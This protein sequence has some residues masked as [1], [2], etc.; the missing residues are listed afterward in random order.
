MGGERTRPGSTRCGRRVREPVVAANRRQTPVDRRRRQSA[1]LHRRAVDLDVRSRRG[2]HLEARVGGPLE[3]VAQILAVRLERSAAVAGQERCSRQLRLVRRRHRLVGERECRGRHDQ[4][5][6]HREPPRFERIH[7]TRLDASGTDGP[8][9]QQPAFGG[10]IRYHG[11]LM[12]HRR[13]MNRTFCASRAAPRRD[14]CALNEAADVID[15]GHDDL[16]RFAPGGRC[17]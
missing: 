11:R 14:I 3:E 12:N 1:L 9:I 8:P 10:S 2:Q 6:R 17:R 15:V 4:S 7:T 13:A 5:C 16:M